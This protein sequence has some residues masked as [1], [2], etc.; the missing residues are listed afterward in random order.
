[1]TIF[2]GAARSYD[3]GAHAAAMGAQSDARRA[4]TKAESLQFDIERLLMIT[5]ALWTLMKDEHGYSDEQ[6]IEKIADIDMRDGKLDGKVN[7]PQIMKCPNC[8]RTLMKHHPACL[9]CGTAVA[10]SPFQR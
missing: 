3:S 10:V 6:L 9:Y 1:M 7:T 4:T 2:Y 8:G 5:E